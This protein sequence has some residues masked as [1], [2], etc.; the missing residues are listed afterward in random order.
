MISLTESQ[1][2]ALMADARRVAAQKRLDT[3]IKRVKADVAVDGDALYYLTILPHYAKQ[4]QAA[5]DRLNRVE[6]EIK[7]ELVNKG[8]KNAKNKV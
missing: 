6:D 1:Q 5:Y 3:V 7:R 4:L 2:R 8:D